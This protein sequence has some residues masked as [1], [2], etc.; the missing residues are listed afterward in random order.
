MSALTRGCVRVLLAVVG[1]LAASATWAIVIDGYDDDWTTWD[2]RNDD[3][4]E[5]LVPDSWD[6]AV[7]LFKWQEQDHTCYFYYRTY[8]TYVP[9]DYDLSAI[10]IDA[11]RNPSTGGSAG[12]RNGLEYYLR[13]DLGDQSGGRHL[14]QATLYVWNGTGWVADGSYAVARNDGGGYTFVEWSLPAS[15]FSPVGGQFYWSAWLLT[16][17]FID[18]PP[19]LIRFNDWCPDSVTQVGFVGALPEPSTWAL[20]GLGL[21]LVAL[22]KR[23]RRA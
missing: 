8:S 20:M 14:G 13:W 9:P 12:L 4:N 22:A 16:G 6:I 2:T 19:R 3:P 1:L 7:N 5:P 15:A 11:D 17:I 10:L 18:E 23:R 21:G